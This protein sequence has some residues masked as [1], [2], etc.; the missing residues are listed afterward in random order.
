MKKH[1][2]FVHREDKSISAEYIFELSDDNEHVV[3]EQIGTVN[4]PS[5]EIPDILIIDG[6]KYLLYQ[7]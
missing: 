6:F 3:K 4:L 7:G 1:G 5:A 2:L